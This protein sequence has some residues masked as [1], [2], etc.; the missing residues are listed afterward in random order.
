M[1]RAAVEPEFAR[2]VA[3]EGSWPLTTD[4]DRLDKPSRRSMSV[5]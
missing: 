3:A 4:C 1:L 2:K 5:G